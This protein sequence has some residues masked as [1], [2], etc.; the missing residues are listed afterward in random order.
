MVREHGDAEE[1]CAQDDGHRH[2]GGRGILRLRAAEGGDAVRDGLHAGQR[3]GA[4]RKPLENEEEAQRAA[5]DLYV[6]CELGIELDGL[7]A[8]E[9]AEQALR[10]TERDECGEDDDVD[11][12]RD[13]E[14]VPG[15]LDAVEVDEADD[16]D[17]RDTEL[18]AMVAEPF[19]LRDRDD[20]GNAGRDRDCDRQDVVDEQRRARD[21]RRSLAEVL[22]ADDIRPSAARIRKDRLPIRRYDDR[23]Q[24]RDGDG[25]RHEDAEAE[26]QVRRL[27]CGDEE[28][29]F[30]RVCGGGD[31]V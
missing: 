16:R 29:L 8:A 28:D 14:D 6:P 19:E 4:R 7:D 12:G 18:D 27:G 31:C 20:R 24:D 26:I 23:E 22:V 11:V 25:N 9:P 3:D 17:E 21:Q 1:Q 10:E 30:G 13:R 5:S 15:F 2:E